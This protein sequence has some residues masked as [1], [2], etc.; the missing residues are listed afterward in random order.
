MTEHY[1]YPCSLARFAAGLGPVAWKIAVK[2]I[3]QSLPPG[4]KFD[5]LQFAYEDPKFTKYEVDVNL[6]PIFLNT[7]KS[8]SNPNESSP[9]VNHEETMDSVR[10][11]RP[12]NNTSQVNGL[13]VGISIDPKQ[14]Q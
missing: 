1:G 11:P 8:N 3:E 5:P 6:M 7:G 4:I 2:K 13:V 10:T 9:I 12:Q 14:E